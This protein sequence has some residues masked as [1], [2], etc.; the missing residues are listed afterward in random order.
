MVRWSTSE[1]N[2]YVGTTTGGVGGRQ[3]IHGPN[4]TWTD[5]ETTRYKDTGTNSLGTER[6]LVPPA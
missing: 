1:L 2:D 4:K 6:I 5:G 3:Q